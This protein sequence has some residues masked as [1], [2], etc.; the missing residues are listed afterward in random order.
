M[1]APLR[2][3]REANCGNSCS[4]Q[5][6][7]TVQAALDLGE[8]DAPADVDVVVRHLQRLE[9]GHAIH[10]HHQRGPCGRGC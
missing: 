5:R 2:I 9:L 10:G 1:V 4:Q 8:R 7:A 3:S 6:D